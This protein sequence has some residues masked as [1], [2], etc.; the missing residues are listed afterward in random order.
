MKIF[1]FICLAVILNAESTYD[2]A[3]QYLDGSKGALKEKRLVPRCPYERCD[4]KKIYIY[5]KKDLKKGYELLNKAHNEG[6]LRASLLA[7][8]I[9]LKQIDYKNKNYDGYLVEKL[10]K[11]YSLDIDEYNKAVI[12]YMTSLALSTNNQFQCKGSFGLYE[13]N[14]R[15]YF[16]INENNSK[17]LDVAKT[18]KEI[19]LVSCKTNSLEHLKLTSKERR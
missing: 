19:A 12:S 3:L 9:L 13:A 18:N 2:R 15:A 17:R 8:N 6:D 14:I 7:L 16:G 11:D 5:V 10:K 1:L 4:G